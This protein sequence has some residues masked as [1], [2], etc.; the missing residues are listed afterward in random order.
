MR[1]SGQAS[2]R[3]GPSQALKE[4]ERWWIRALP[5]CRGRR[6]VGDL[7]RASEGRGAGT[8]LRCGSSCQ[9]EII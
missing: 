8:E 9:Q 3:R 2:W 6:V 4:G 7:Y 1:W 5:W